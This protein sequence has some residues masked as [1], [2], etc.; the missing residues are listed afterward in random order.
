MRLDFNAT[1]RQLS[2]Q[3]GQNDEEIPRFADMFLSFRLLLSL[4]ETKCAI[5]DLKL[6]GMV[7]QSAYGEP[8]FETLVIVP[9][10][11]GGPRTS[12]T[13]HI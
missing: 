7:Q 1:H 11:A 3:S 5:G 4:I 8:R 12:L 6:V 13:L 2:K 9:F 10:Q